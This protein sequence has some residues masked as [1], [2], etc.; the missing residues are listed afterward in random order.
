[1]HCS[2]R[3]YYTLHSAQ[4]VHSG[5]VLNT[6]TYQHMTISDTIFRKRHL[7]R[8]FL[9]TIRRR[10]HLSD[11]GGVGERRPDVGVHVELPVPAEL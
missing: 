10:A 8:S 4:K 2:E 5:C 9:V 11:E 3:I 7:N 1:M 6:H